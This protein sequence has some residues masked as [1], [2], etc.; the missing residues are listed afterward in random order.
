M[1]IA[2]GSDHAGFE[3]RLQIKQW[4][5]D[6]Q[7]EVIDT[8]TYA[9]TSVDYPEYAWKVAQ[10]ILSGSCAYGI[11]ICGSGIGMSIAANRFCGIRAALCFNV[12]TARLSRLHNDANVLVFGA[13]Q[14][15]I[16]LA[17]AML[18][19]WLNTSF[20]GERHNLR[21]AQIEQYARQER[22]R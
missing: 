17:K 5:E 2:I 3:M 8:G 12:E 22:E 4:L 7:F 10:V 20:E 11:L 13:R 19:V 18:D 21:I 14:I 16:A 9:Q 15:D 1:Q 6:H